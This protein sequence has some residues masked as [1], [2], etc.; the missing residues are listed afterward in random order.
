MYDVY[1]YIYTTHEAKEFILSSSCIYTRLFLD[2]ICHTCR[3]NCSLTHF[4][5]E[6]VSAVSFPAYIPSHGMLSKLRQPCA[7]PM[8]KNIYGSD[9]VLPHVVLQLCPSHFAGV[10]VRRRLGAGSA[11]W[12]LSGASAAAFALALAFSRFGSFS[13]RVCCKTI[14]CCCK[15][16]RSEAS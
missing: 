2:L 10:F 13:R 11:T 7:N 5:P 16:F 1:I 3:P 8:Y 9:T 15:A 6:L 4:Y 12:A 14:A